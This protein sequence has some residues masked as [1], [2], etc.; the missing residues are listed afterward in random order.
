LAV[1]PRNNPQKTSDQVFRY[2]NAYLHVYNGRSDKLCFIRSTFS[3]RPVI[4]PDPWV[5]LLVVTAV[6]AVIKPAIV[7]QSNTRGSLIGLCSGCAL[8]V[9]FVARFLK[10]QRSVILEILKN[11]YF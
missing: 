9:S 6:T 10:N 1:P 8:D 3:G 11:G 5:G 7:V 4:A 2:C